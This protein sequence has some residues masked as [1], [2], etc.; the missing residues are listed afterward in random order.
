MWQ[1][2]VSHIACTFPFLLH[3]ILACAALHLAYQNP[4]QR[5]ELMIRG[6]SHQ[7]HAMPLFGSAIANPNKDN[8]DVV[9][10]FTHLLVI[11]SF[12][13]EREDER[14]LLVE[15]NALDVLPSWL[16]FIRSGCSMLCDVWD[17]LEP[18]LVGPLIS[19]WVIPTIFSEAEQTRL[20]SSL[21]SAIPL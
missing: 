4:G 16:Y 10:A 1:V 11:Y 6:G 15:S 2:T 7:D 8:C 13:A 17:Q 18:G 20:M 21:L 12:A 14:L 19:A 9:F 3:G 5:R